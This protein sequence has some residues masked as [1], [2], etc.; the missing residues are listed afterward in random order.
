M[1]TMIGT[2][3][4][5]LVYIL[6]CTAISGMF[7]AAKVAAS[8]APFSLAAGHM[9][10]AWA[11]R[12]V[13][14]VTAFACLASLG[15]WMMLVSQAGARAAAD[16]T[17]PAW[18]GNKNHKGIPVVGLVST[19]VFMSI[20]MVLLMFLTKGGN[21]QDLFGEIASIAVLLTLPPYFYSALNL[22]QQRGFRDRK[23][24]VN[25]AIAVLASVFCFTALAGAKR[26]YLAVAVIT[27]FA[28]FIFY[29][30]KKRGVQEPPPPVNK[31]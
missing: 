15:S 4:A 8:G 12:L 11:P 28:V 23:A 21:T 25:S 7:P 20:L 24:I 29:A 16:G 9:F 31:A 19:S 13:S 17:L 26:M 6:S 14:G 2:C 5:G 3:V 1:A 27:M 10:G 18:F 30:G 22:L